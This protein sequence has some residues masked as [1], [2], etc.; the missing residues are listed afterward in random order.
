MFVEAYKSALGV[1]TKKPI[2]LWGLS[3][4]STVIISVAC[5][6]TALLPV[7]GILFAFLISCGMKKVYLDGLAGKEVNSDQLFAAFGKNTGRV[8]GGMSWQYLWMGIWACVPIAGIVKFYAYSFVPY[9]LMTKPEVSATEAL[10]LS[11]KMTDGHK[12]QLFLADLCFALALLVVW[13]VLGLFAAIPYIGVLFGIALF[14]VALAVMLF[15]GVFMGLVKA[16]FFTKLDT[17][18]APAVEE[19]VAAE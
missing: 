11:M 6:F 13:F 10:R 16:W 5:G 19:A 8:L 7:V 14:L 9:I 18:E 2:M 17:Q 4:L 3:L 12:T 15:G 1:L